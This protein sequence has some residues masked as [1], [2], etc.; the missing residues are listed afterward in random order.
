MD[1]PAVVSHF[2]FGYIY[3]TFE[4]SSAALTK[5][6]FG[7]FLPK[8]V[9]TGQWQLCTTKL[10]SCKA[11]QW[12]YTCIDTHLWPSCGL[13]SWRILREQDETVY[14]RNP[15]LE[16]HRLTTKNIPVR[17]EKKKSLE[18]DIRKTLRCHIRI[19]LKM[20]PREVHVSAFAAAFAC[21]WS[22]GRAKSYWTIRSFGSVK[23]KKK[24]YT[25]ST[26]MTFFQLVDPFQT[27]QLYQHIKWDPPACAWQLLFCVQGNNPS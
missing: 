12:T 24:R 10:A 18:C 8:S 17:G 7:N 16:R 13:S 9:R 5:E 25:L 23:K 27:Q 26:R 14:R 3:S 21:Y 6:Y 15:H 22:G 11:R 2:N 19:L 1:F 20:Q 4:I